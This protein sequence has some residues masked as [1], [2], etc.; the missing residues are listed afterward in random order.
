MLLSEA[1]VIIWSKCY[2][3]VLSPGMITPRFFIFSGNFTYST[4]NTHC[5]LVWRRTF[6]GYIFLLHPAKVN[7]NLFSFSL[8]LIE[9]VCIKVILYCTYHPLDM[10]R[11]TLASFYGYPLWIQSTHT[12]ICQRIEPTSCS[13]KWILGVDNF[14]YFLDFGPEKEVPASPVMWV[15]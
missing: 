11:R 10:E 12:S 4:L 15:G 9:N 5:Y 2:H 3:L 14:F 6:S 13:K 8:L 1:N 7:T